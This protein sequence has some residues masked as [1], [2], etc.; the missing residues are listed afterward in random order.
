MGVWPMRDTGVSPVRV[1]GV[2]PMRVF[3]AQPP[4]A[5]KPACN[6]LHAL[7]FQALRADHKFCRL[8]RGVI[9]PWN[10]GASSCALGSS[11]RLSGDLTN[12]TSVA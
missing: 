8:R 6:Q 5:V 10:A 1:M 7:R 3:V 2:S 12:K 4:S 11:D 9:H